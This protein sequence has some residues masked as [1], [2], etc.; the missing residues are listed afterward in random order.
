ME[1]QDL[2]EQAPTSRADMLSFKQTLRV[3]ITIS[4]ALHRR[5]TPPYPQHLIL[6]FS[7]VSKPVGFPIPSITTTMSVYRSHESSDVHTPDHPLPVPTLSRNQN[8]PC[9]MIPTSSQITSTSTSTSYSL[10][11]KCRALVTSYATMIGAYT[12]F[13]NTDIPSHT[14]KDYDMAF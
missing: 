2:F 3:L 11:T 8:E 4:E 14:S 9:K 7:P 10:Q 1:E 5:Y 13:Y 6:P 12:M